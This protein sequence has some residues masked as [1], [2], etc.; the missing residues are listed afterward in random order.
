[1]L[2]T[3]RTP[4]ARAIRAVRAPGGQPEA[5]S[6]PESRPGNPAGAS[7]LRTSQGDT[8]A[9][10]PRGAY[11]SQAT[12]RQRQGSGCGLPGPADAGG[13][14]AARLPVIQW[15]LL[16]LASACARLG[17]LYGMQTGRPAA[18]GPSTS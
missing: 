10:Q 2:I 11:L 6:S 17:A 14:G 7:G 18:H 15:K 13:K 12:W 1:V 8:R 4:R 9:G 3:P 5:S 16:A